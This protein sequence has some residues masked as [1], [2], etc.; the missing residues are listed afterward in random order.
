MRVSYPAA[1]DEA[2]EGR[3]VARPGI[4][5]QLPREGRPRERQANVI[6][7]YKPSL[8]AGASGIPKKSLNGPGERPSPSAEQHPPS[9]SSVSWLAKRL[10]DRLDLQYSKAK[11][12][13]DAI[14][15]KIE[16]QEKRCV[17]PK[18]DEDLQRIRFQRQ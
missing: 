13:L 10:Q 5:A 17:T 18:L 7:R 15:Y 14:A 4:M 16:A 11:A 9:Q 8:E 12:R 6:A 1:S 2:L 3:G